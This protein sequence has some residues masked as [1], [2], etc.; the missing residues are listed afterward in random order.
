MRGAELGAPLAL[1]FRSAVASRARLRKLAL[2]YTV[3][4]PAALA[5]DIVYMA[6]PAAPDPG[7]SPAFTAAR[8]SWSDAWCDQ[9]TEIDCPTLIIWGE[10][11]A[12]LPLRHA[13]EWARRIRGSEL[14]VVPDAGHLP[15]LERP[16]LVNGL[17][18]AF[19]QRLD[20]PDR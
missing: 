12:L 3:A 2:K 17:L 19:L 6:L 9:L 14:H 5:A 20:G 8:R 4:D 18:E 13:R 7:F 11:D 15:M 10:R 1:R 16:L